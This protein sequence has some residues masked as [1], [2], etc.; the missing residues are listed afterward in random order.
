MLEKSVDEFAQEEFPHDATPEEQLCFL[1]GFAVK[2]LQALRVD[3]SQSRESQ[4]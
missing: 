2:K 3:P 1:I 4:Q